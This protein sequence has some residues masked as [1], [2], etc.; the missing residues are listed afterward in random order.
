MND[1]NLVDIWR[2]KNPD[3]RR[4]TWRKVVHKGIQQ[5]RLDM[6]LIANSF[7]YKMNETS[8]DTSILSDH[9]LIT[10][11][12]EAIGSIKNRGRGS[13]KLNTSLLKEKEYVNMINIVIEECKDKYRNVSDKRLKWDTI[14]MEIRS[15]TISYAVYRA[16]EKRALENEILDTIK[17]LETEMDKNPT[18]DI[19]QQYMTCF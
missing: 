12:L 7:I 17:E 8:I 14:K 5:S 6:W 2:I 19:K 15:S 10:L 1:N 3:T 11:K 9:N 13:W 18:E 16:K 4:Y